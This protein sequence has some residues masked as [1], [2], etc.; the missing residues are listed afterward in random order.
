LAGPRVEQR[1]AAILAADVAGYT[2]LMADDEAATVAALDAARAVF[3]REIEA[4]HGRV[5]DMAGDSVLAVFA[6]ATGA[7]RAACAIQQAL[8]EVDDEAGL[9]EQRRMRFRIGVNLGEVMEKADGTVYGAGVNVAARLES[10]ADPGGVLVSDKVYAEA[11]GRVAFGFADAGSHQ[12]KNVPAPV[13][14]YRVSPSQT[15]A[16]EAAGSDATAASIFT[17]PAVAVLP[18]NN[19]SGDPE[20][21]YFVDGL[22]EDIITALAAWRSFPVIAR[23]STFAYKGQ[24]PDIRKVGEELGARYILEGGVRKGGNRLRITAQLIDASN[25]YHIW[26]ERFDRELADIFELQDEITR[27]IAAT[28][29]PEVERAEQKRLV[30]A[31]PRNLRAWDYYQRGMALLAEFTKDGNA[32][33]RE[34]FGKAIA[35]DPGYSLAHAGLAF[36]HN[37]DL[38]LQVSESRADSA[39]RALEAALKAVEL[40]QGDSMAHTMLAVAYTWP[41][42][43]EASV[44][45]SQRAVELNPSNAL[46][47]AMLGTS[48]DAVGRHDE[49]IE[50]LEQALQI[51]PRDPS[52]HIYIA[53][54]ARAHLSARRYE[55]AAACARKAITHRSSYP[56]AHYILASALA[57]LGR[58]NEAR[59]ALDTCERLQPGYVEGRL[60]WQPYSD[61]AENQHLHAG[62]RKVVTATDGPA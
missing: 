7:V 14:A 33:A 39:A 62:I 52:T 22:T 30:A 1:L 6:T 29:A 46:A 51:N 16:A 42:Q 13:Q 32:R 11:A 57:Q 12:V 9:A 41:S 15:S 37:R 59:A 19:M 24:A 38:L 23:N 10:L 61:A 5:V 27:R 20:Q 3:R 21:D 47:L 8:A 31:E 49:G 55:Q 50:R 17:R 54:I 60:R 58:D 34:M 45:E 35:L 4:E 56:H 26:A 44:V 43:Y 25:G 40:D 36:T 48:L 28:V 18:F 53:T 2:R